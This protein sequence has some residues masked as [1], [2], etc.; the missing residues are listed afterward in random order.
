[1]FRMLIV[2]DEPI[3]VEGLQELFE[4]LEHLELEILIAY[5]G[6][7]ALDALQSLR[8]DIVLSDIEMPEMNG[9]LLQQEAIRIGSA[10]KF[11]FL[12]GYN[13]FDY[14]QTTSRSGSLDF[15]VKTEGDDP[16]IAAVEKAIAAIQEALNMDRL[17]KEARYQ[18]QKAHPILKREL[19]L[20]CLNG[21][22]STRNT[23]ASSFQQYQ[24]T[25]D[26]SRPV[27]AVLGRI[28]HWRHEQEEA[29]KALFIYCIANIMEEFFSSRCRMEHLSESDRRMIWLIQPLSTNDQ[30]LA[31]NFK[32]YMMSSLEAVQNA[33]R[34]Y[35]KIVCS[36][37]AM[38]KECTWDALPL[39]FNRLSLLFER[40]LGLGSEM[41][42]TDE[43]MFA[44][45]DKDL[46]LQLRGVR[47]LDTALAK[48]D[49]DEF[50]RKY[51]EI[52]ALFEQSQ[53]YNP[54]LSL[55]IFYELSSIFIA[56]LNRLDLLYSLSER[57]PIG[58]LL[59]IQA[60]GSWK[61]VS[62]FF[63]RIA[64]H[65]FDSA[66]KEIET[67]TNEI[68]A[69][70]H[71]YVKDHLNG[72]LSLNRLAE[73]VYLTPFYLSRLYKRITGQSISDFIME[74]RLDRAKQLLGDP[75]L[76]IHDVGQRVGCESPSYFGQFFKK[77][78]GLTP[79]EY[80]DSLKR[81]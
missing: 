20:S 55:E 60:H 56:H 71:S 51:H 33:S 4:E 46:R 57:Y 1:M 21:D 67:E 65:I 23:L 64:H 7:Q 50:F 81:I 75:A 79:Q 36:F 31:D 54:G 14:I 30:E 78:T 13:D 32:S 10:A 69:T 5:N 47:L 34:T 66:Q 37:A 11:I 62:S 25:L 44:P 12:T 39:G 22:H 52:M 80:R 49:K 6:R 35:L 43:R 16:I 42:L 27:Y 76:K 2:D 19:L 9:L 61:D 38:S 70:L 77:H 53:N 45:S 58:H 15:I 29:D 74:A 63:E 18:M 68:V 48:Q 72:D 73:L 28:D 40:G 26:P 8:I 41:L 3:I 24:I 59:S 17:L